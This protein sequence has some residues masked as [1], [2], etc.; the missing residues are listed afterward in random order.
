MGNSKSI[1]Q[2][3][4]SSNEIDLNDK[5]KEIMTVIPINNQ[6]D[7]IYNNEFNF[8]INN[9]KIS[10]PLKNDEI[11]FFISLTPF[12]NDNN[13]NNENESDYYDL[14]FSFDI[15]PSM[16]KTYMNKNSNDTKLKLILDKFKNYLNNFNKINSLI[17]INVFSN[18]FENILKL[19]KFNF[20]NKNE[21]ENLLNFQSKNINSPVDQNIFLE[22]FNAA[23]NSLNN[24]KNKKKYLIIFS[25]YFYSFNNKII[26]DYI[27]Q[28]IR[29]N[30]G[31]IFIDLNN[32]LNH[33]LNLLC[34]K[35]KLF[36][37]I[38]IKN[39]E[40]LENLFSDNFKYSIEPLFHDLNIEIKSNDFEI[41]NYYGIEKKEDKFH[42]ENIFQTKCLKLNDNQIYIKSNFFLFQ[43][44]F[45]NNNYISYNSNE[46][47]QFTLDYSYY[48]RLNVYEK[49]SINY[50]CE[51]IIN[52]NENFYQSM[53]NIIVMNY[54]FEIKKKFDDEIF[55]INDKKIKSKNNENF[56]DP[57]GNVIIK[58]E[59]KDYISNLKYEV[60]NLKNYIN[61]NFKDD[62][63]NN[64]NKNFIINELDFLNNKLDHELVDTK[65]ED[66]EQI[67]VIV[68]N[69]DET[70]DM[71][72]E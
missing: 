48:N 9:C 11:S 32:Y 71:T 14:I 17:G 25:D 69:K 60:I 1:N 59:K 34:E 28:F 67:E 19:E 15:S 66:E 3:N 65:Y 10:S 72:T 63:N 57:F 55:D 42:K 4:N 56:F 13:N 43:I 29:N 40:D 6:N 52:E 31:I 12:A 64:Y 7:Q 70:N 33:N 20:S 26:N 23:F 37:Y 36:N 41:L 51:F 21:Y 45:N 5:I 62:L 68:E 39:E 54:M 18:K 53:K 2:I 50:N 24:S 44:K 22:M 47:C 35:S 30:I 49:K 38:H 8:I 46:K 58:Y 61:N 16:S 27:N